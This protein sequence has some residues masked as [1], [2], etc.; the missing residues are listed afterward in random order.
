[1]RVEVWVRAT[2]IKSRDGAE[3]SYFP[4]VEWDDPRSQTPMSAAERVWRVCSSGALDLTEDEK[5]W[6]AAWSARRN[7]YGF[8]VG[9][10]VVA[11]GTS[12][13]C[14]RTGFEPCPPPT[15]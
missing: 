10:I 11:D 3:A 14:T 12:L 6:Q 8:G 7:G 5:R 2:L 4:I 9:D 15:A 13:R 1:M